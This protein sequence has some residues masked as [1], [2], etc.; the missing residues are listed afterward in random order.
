MISPPSYLILIKTKDKDKKK[1]RKN[2]T[3]QKSV[4]IVI[5]SSVFLSAITLKA[6]IS[7]DKT[8][9]ESLPLFPFPSQRFGCAL[10]PS[11]QMRLKN[12]R[13]AQDYRP[14]DEDCP[15]STCRQYT[16]AYLHTLV[17][18]ENVACSLVTVHNVA[19][20]V[21]ERLLKLYIRVICYHIST[22]NWLTTVTICAIRL[23][24]RV[25]GL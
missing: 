15:C 10:V 5:V 19:Y 4:W 14:I 7:E 21:R 12:K 3:G 13:F 23:P 18:N 24:S 9:H 11:G 1:T 6:K 25:S 22:D 17:T 16:R 20:Q 2:L 8:Q